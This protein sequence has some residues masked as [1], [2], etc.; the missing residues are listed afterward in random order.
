MAQFDETASTREEIKA[1]LREHFD[2]RIVRK[3]LTKK[4]KEGANVPVYVLE[5]L[6]G[7][8]CSSDDDEVIERG[9][10]NVKRILADN[11]VRPDEAQKILSLLRSRGSYTIIDK[12]TVQLNIKND[13]Y[14]ADFSNLGLKAIPNED[15][16]PEKY[17][18]LLCGG[19]WSIVQLT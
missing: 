18:R 15:E 6:L 4:I 10:Q 16:Y 11:F 14:E 7:Q 12:V 2:G 5:F 8:Y 9:V 1:K 19:I 17:D 3:D 13:C